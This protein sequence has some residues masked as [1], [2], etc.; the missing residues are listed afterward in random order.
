MEVLHSVPVLE[1]IGD[2]EWRASRAGPECNSSRTGPLDS[3]SSTGPLWRGSILVQFWRSVLD[4]YG[5]TPFWSSS[6]DL[7]WTVMK[8]LHSGP[9]LELCTGPLMETLPFWSSL[10]KQRLEKQ[11]QRL[12]S[13]GSL[14]HFI[15]RLSARYLK[16]DSQ[17]SDS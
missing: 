1:S 4:R 13:R 5:G 6:G 9:V 15:T 16:M 10:E 12:P 3:F 11:R 2:P 7:Y 17:P 8:M 14:V